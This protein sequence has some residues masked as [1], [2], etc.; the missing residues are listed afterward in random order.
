MEEVAGVEEALFVDDETA[1]FYRD[2]GE[3]GGSG[4][5]AAS[6]RQP[7]AHQKCDNALCDGIRHFG[8]VLRYA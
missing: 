6:H 3:E 1:A 5:L 4:D 8:S 7:D 2:T